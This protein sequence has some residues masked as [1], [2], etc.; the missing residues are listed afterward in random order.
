M[1]Q[2]PIAENLFTW[3]SVS[4]RLLA[5]R[6]RRC[7]AHSFPVQSGC[8]RCG[9]VDLETIELSPSGRIWTWT[10][11][12]FLPKAPPYTGPETDKT[13]VP[14]FVGYVEVD[15]KLHIEARLVGFEDRIP[16]IGEE[17]SLVIIPFRTD[18]QG[19][20]IVIPAFAPVDADKGGKNA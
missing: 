13:F 2:I 20:E 16:E 10:S 12:D 15:D 11:Q 17:V 19:N 3:P 4:P 14:Y 1:T 5:C 6:C 7:D 9:S 18:E 8:A